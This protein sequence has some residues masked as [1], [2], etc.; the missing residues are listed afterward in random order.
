MEDFN[1]FLM[2]SNQLTESDIPW[3]STGVCEKLVLSYE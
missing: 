2:R 1:S 3:Q